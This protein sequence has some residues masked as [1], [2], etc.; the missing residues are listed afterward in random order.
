MV[1]K[2][3]KVGIHE[4]K[5]WESEHRSGEDIRSSGQTTFSENILRNIDIRN[6]VIDENTKFFNKQITIIPVFI[7]PLKYDK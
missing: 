1:K 2:K 3:R 4:I 7:P 5:T 6:M